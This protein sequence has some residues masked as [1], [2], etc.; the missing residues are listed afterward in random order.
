MEQLGDLPTTF[1]SK[2]GWEFCIE[3]YPN[4]CFRCIDNLNCNFGSGPCSSSTLTRSDGPEPF[5]TPHDAQLE[6]LVREVGQEM[7]LHNV[8]IRFVNTMLCHF[9][10]DLLSI[11]IN[12]MALRRHQ[13]IIPSGVTLQVLLFVHTMLLH[14]SFGD[15][16]FWLTGAESNEIVLMIMKLLQL[17]LHVPD[18][19]FS[20][21]LAVCH[22]VKIH[23]V[24]DT[25]QGFGAGNSVSCARIWTSRRI[26]WNNHTP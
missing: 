23:Y 6:D 8:K 4:W 10:L 7:Q 15:R 20:M 24:L 2:M 25:Q 16:L 26:N 11:F 13:K 19:G 5:L 9:C 18:R 21:V 3:Q 1:P 22:K 17:L 14:K 12:K